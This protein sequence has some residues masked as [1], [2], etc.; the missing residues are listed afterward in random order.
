[1]ACGTRPKG[2]A[3]I[4]DRDLK[5]KRE[6][7]EKNKRAVTPELLSERSEIE[8]VVPTTPTREPSAST[9]P[10]R[11][12]GENNNGDGRTKRKRKPTVIY[13]EAR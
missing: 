13:E 12:A 2:I 11:L 3:E 7:R 10:A 6:E 5:G 8:I 9:A 4:G 1:M